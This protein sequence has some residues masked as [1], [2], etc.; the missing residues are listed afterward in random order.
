MECINVHINR[1]AGCVYCGIDFWRDITENGVRSN[2]RVGIQYVEAWLLGNGCV[3][4]YH[5][6]EDAAT[7]EISRAQLWQWIHHNS[8]LNDGRKIT[9]DN[10]DK[11]LVEELKVIESEIGT[12]RFN[13]GRFHEASN[14]FS[15]M[16]KKEVFDEFLTIPAYEL[17]N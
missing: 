1:S 11:W 12:K 14:L 9:V 6:M 2:I 13:S 3:P 5:L 4:L 15:E 17:L 10:F 16:I 7:A 8:N